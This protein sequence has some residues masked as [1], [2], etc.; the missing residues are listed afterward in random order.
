V[1]IDGALLARLK[2]IS[3]VTAIVGSGASA[4][5]YAEELPQNP[6][7]DA[8]VFK[9]VNLPRVHASGADPG[10]V[11]GRVQV[12]AW[13]N[14]YEGARDLGDAIRGDNA[15]SALSRWSG[16]EDTTVIDDMF[17]E[18]EIPLTEPGVGSEDRL[19]RNS[20]DYMVHYKE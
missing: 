1:T 10:I 16:T 19:Y 2:D 6:R 17:L 20:Q 9:I 15:G 5:I 14:S 18:N 13:S 7:F 4:R 8:I 3:A 12:D 11:R